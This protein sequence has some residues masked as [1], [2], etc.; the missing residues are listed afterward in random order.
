MKNIFLTV[1]LAA[2]LLFSS[3]HI[4]NAAEITQ[5]FG[6]FKIDNVVATEKKEA[7]KSWGNAE[8]LANICQ[9]PAKVVIL[10][11]EVR[12]MWYYQE[13]VVDRQLSH[14]NSPI[15]NL[16]PDTCAP[17]YSFYIEKPGIYSVFAADE[18][19]FA[20]IGSIIVK[21]D[22][23]P[24]ASKVYI[25]GKEIAFDAYNIGDNNYFKLRDIAMALKGSGKEFN[26]GWNAEKAS[27]SLEKNTPYAIVGGELQ[28]GSV[29]VAEATPNLSST[30]L[31]GEAYGFISY[32][33]N[34]N[35]YFKL[36]D[37]G[38]ALGFSVEWDADTNS[39]HI[40]TTNA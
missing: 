6:W 33:I 4:V 36:R 17:G 37:L 28:A 2:S 1:A 39:I 24:T 8:N 34:D 27:I 23:Q 40:S 20:G 32:T 29:V 22:A 26:V 9:A 13:T 31:D 14:S 5:Q 35:N 30:Y 21:G 15:V 25:D 38:D 11:E 16:G 19:L 3:I 7:I 18:G 10:S 12:E